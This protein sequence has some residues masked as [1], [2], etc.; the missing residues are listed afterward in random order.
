MNSHILY[1][2]QRNKCCELTVTLVEHKNSLEDNVSN[3]NFM[4]DRFYSRSKANYT[5]SYKPIQS[6]QMVC[7]IENIMKLN[8]NRCG[9]L[10]E[11]NRY[12]TIL[13]L[14]YII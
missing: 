10:A 5:H 11:L 12:Q 8:E 9:D 1:Y 2:L 4:I 14:W 3:S 13:L 6:I 7:K